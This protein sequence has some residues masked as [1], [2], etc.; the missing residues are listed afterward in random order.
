MPAGDKLVQPTG[1]DGFQ[2]NRFR[3]FNGVHYKTQHKVPMLHPSR[4][5]PSLAWTFAKLPSGPPARL[6]T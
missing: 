5:K 3:A 1:N 6:Q 2:P 4:M